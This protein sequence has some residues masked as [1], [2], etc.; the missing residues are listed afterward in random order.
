[1]DRARW[2]PNM[3]STS[4]WWCHREKRLCLTEK[5]LKVTSR[6]PLAGSFEVVEIT[7]GRKEQFAREW[8]Q[9]STSV[10]RVRPDW[11]PHHQYVAKLGKPEIS[12]VP[13]FPPCYNPRKARQRRKSRRRCIPKEL[14]RQ[15]PLYSETLM[16]EEGRKIRL[17]FSSLSF[18]PGKEKMVDLN[19]VWGWC[20]KDVMMW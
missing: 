3:S 14:H 9:M 15:G 17:V 11:P 1:M 10:T 8:D 5:V 19:I 18:P 2:R 4:R 13:P 16:W 7:S 20:F 12:L 6:K